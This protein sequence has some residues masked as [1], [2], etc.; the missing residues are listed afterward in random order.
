MAVSQ[1]TVFMLTKQ[2][3]ILICGFKALLCLLSP[4]IKINPLHQHFFHR[5]IQPGD[6]PANNQISK[7]VSRDQNIR[8]KP[9][10]DNS[11]QPVNNSNSPTVHSDASFSK[12][13]SELPLVHKQSSGVIPQQ[14]Y[15]LV[16]PLTLFLLTDTGKNS[17]I[18]KGPASNKRVTAR[19]KESPSKTRKLD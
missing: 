13:R 2:F 12:A 5:L 19:S 1:S 4:P 15:S 10:P 6:T 18:K 3:T 14:N 11:E 8:E 9:Q 16:S 7:D 17:E